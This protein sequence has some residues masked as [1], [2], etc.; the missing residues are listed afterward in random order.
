MLLIMKKKYLLINYLKKFIKADISM[1]DYS[2]ECKIKKKKHKGRYNCKKC[3]WYKK[4]IQ[5]GKNL[6]WNCTF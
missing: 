1:K 4:T 5:D 2:N 3:I 6:K